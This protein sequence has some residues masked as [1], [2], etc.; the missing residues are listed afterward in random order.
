MVWVKYVGFFFKD[1]IDEVAIFGQALS[2][3]QIKEIYY[4]G[5]TGENC[6][7]SADLVTAGGYL[8]SIPEDPTEGNAN[9]S[10][11]LIKRDPSG[12]ITVK[13]PHASDY[14]EQEILVSR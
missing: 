2:D 1:T 14:A 10:G 6:D 4:Y 5:L 3:D 11:Y 7:L 9:N 12:S 8:S 13:A